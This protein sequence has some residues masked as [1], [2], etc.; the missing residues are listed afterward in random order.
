MDLKNGSEGVVK[1]F[2]ILQLLP[3]TKSQKAH[4]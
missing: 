2:N 3:T 4:I 1:V